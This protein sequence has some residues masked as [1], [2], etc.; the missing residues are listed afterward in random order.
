MGLTGDVSLEVNDCG[1][2][3]A[4]FYGLAVPDLRLEVNDRGVYTRRVLDPRLPLGV[5]A[6]TTEPAAIMRVLL[7]MPPPSMR[8]CPKPF[9]EV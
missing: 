2:T 4:A 9:M 8:D 6:G 1:F 5:L 7:A 3:P